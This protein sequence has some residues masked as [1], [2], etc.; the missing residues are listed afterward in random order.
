MK[1]VFLATAAAVAF[2]ATAASAESLLPVPVMG[3][4]EYA[5]E[6]ET[7]TLDLGTQL[8]VGAI[9]ITPLA[10]FDDA[11][12]TFEFTSAEVTVSYMIGNNVDLYATVEGDQDFGHAETTVG[13]AFSF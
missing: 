2:T 4:F 3:S 10:T 8:T 13:V 5:T 6:A 1:N 12:D 11:G 7:M 9:A